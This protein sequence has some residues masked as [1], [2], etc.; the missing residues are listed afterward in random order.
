MVNTYESLNERFPILDVLIKH[1][2]CADQEKGLLK[3]LFVTIY[4]V[5]YGDGQADR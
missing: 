3:E 2:S 1:L 4:N 5:G